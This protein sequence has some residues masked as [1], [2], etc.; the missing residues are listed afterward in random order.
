MEELKPIYD[1]VKSYYGKAII[2]SYDGF[3][4]L[5]SYSDNVSTIDTSK[6]I[7]IIWDNA[8]LTKTTL[9]HIKEFLKQ[10]GFVIGSKEKL[11]KMYLQPNL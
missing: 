11:C 10:Y 8:I 6:H 7:A 5:Q 2:R 9:R 3:I 1:N 4:S